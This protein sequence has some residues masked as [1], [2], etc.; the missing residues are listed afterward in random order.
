[1]LLK[2]IIRFL[3]YED[4]L[5]VRDEVVSVDHD[6]K[7]MM[8]KLLRFDALLYGIELAYLAGKKYGRGRKDLLKK[9]SCTGRDC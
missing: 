5:A 2:K 1:M 3:R 6:R 8:R 4:T 9:V 7:M